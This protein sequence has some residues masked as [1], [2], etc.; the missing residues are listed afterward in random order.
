MLFFHPLFPQRSAILR[1]FSFY[2]PSVLGPDSFAVIP[3]VL[4]K[5]IA[6]IQLI[7]VADGKRVIS[8][9][10]AHPLAKIS[11]IE[12]NLFN[13]SPSLQCDYCRERTFMRIVASDIEFLEPK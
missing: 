6:V 10:P 9:Y 3:T 7:P 2:L 12:K 8:G 11:L 4:M 13:G 5:N 1:H